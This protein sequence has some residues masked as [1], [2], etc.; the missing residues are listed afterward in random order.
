[1]KNLLVGAAL[2]LLAFSANAYQLSFSGR[3]T[4][5]DGSLSGI[6]AGS[7]IEGSLI[8]DGPPSAQFTS[9]EPY[10]SAV[11]SASGLIS[12]N[13]GSHTIKAW[14]PSITIVNNFGGN[15]E[16][17]FT[18]NGSQGLDVDGTPYTD[19]VFGFALATGPGN[20]GVLLDL[21]LPTTLDVARFDAWA[22]GYLH[23]DGGPNG[24]LMEFQVMSVEVAA[25][26]EP[27]AAWMLMGGLLFVL[28]RYRG[29]A[30]RPAVPAIR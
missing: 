28:R 20:S 17:T 14:T 15:V 27:E 25:V 16:D 29:N 9:H 12:A 23:R 22:Y 2:W 3:V 10:G 30:R 26:P 13:V 21:S 6:G 18:L 11:Y 5:T 19:G 1:M 8:S 4:Y 7:V 24:T